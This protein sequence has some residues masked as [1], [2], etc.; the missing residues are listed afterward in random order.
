MDKKTVIFASCIVVAVLG[1]TEWRVSR[2][3]K[4]LVTSIRNI[5]EELSRNTFHVEYGDWRSYRYDKDPV[6]NMA[7]QLESMKYD[8]SNIDDA[9]YKVVEELKYRSR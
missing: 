9:L 7:R 8:I 2:F 1:Y 5:D 6:E 3:E 4:N